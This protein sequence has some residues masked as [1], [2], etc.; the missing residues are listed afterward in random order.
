MATLRLFDS[1]QKRKVEFVP[2][3]PGEVRMYLCGPTVQS[4]PHIGHARGAVAF[5]VVR[6]TF[7]WRGYKVTFVRNITDIDDKII[8]R[9]AELGMTPKELAQRHADDYRAS[10]AAVG[11]SPPDHEPLVT[12]NIPQIIS[13]I[14]RLIDRGCAYPS[15][16]DVYFA[17][18]S[19]PAYG[20]LSGQTIEELRAGARVEPGEHKRNP[21]DFALWKAAKPGEPFW[22]SP[23]GPGRPG[24]HIECSAM[25]M[26]Y[27]G[28]T[29]DIHG[30]GKDLVFPH[31][32]NEIAQSQ[33]AT[34]PGTFS[35]YWMHNGFVNFNDEKMSKSL[36]NVFLVSDLTKKY[37]GETV[38]F[39]LIQTHYRSPINFEVG[40]KDARP[41]FPGLEEAERRLDYFYSTL[42][43]LEDFLGEQREAS[44]PVLADAERLIPALQEAMDDDFNTSVAVAELG[45]AAKLANKLM[46]DP[47][48]AP[49]DLR[50]RS[51]AR[52]YNDIRGA[53][54]GALGLFGQDPRAFVVRRRSRLAATKGIDE[55]AIEN[56]LVLRETARKAKDFAHADQL[57]A[58]LRDLGVEVMDTPRGPDWRIRE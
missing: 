4:S 35:R 48:S 57:R 18:E 11:V 26:R 52:L 1:F 32:E 14:G 16:G 22:E 7:A 41:V 45:E 55:A 17:V 39:F 6:R 38:R 31:H 30:G 27:L 9:A 37:E 40:E 29:F 24:W 43:R 25:T 8:K 50:R 58:E 47:K 42:L 44:G 51:L 23:W 19:F 15:G 53:G 10:M 34:G 2:C 12:E 21:L 49:K 56:R 36:G 13:L 5:D 54:T 28:D 33:G 3:V 20:A 46:D